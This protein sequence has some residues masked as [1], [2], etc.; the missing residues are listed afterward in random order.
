MYALLRRSRLPSPGWLDR[1]SAGTGHG[2]LGSYGRYPPNAVPVGEDGIAIRVAL[3]FYARRGGDSRMEGTTGVSGRT[4][5]E[6][7]FEEFLQEWLEEV[8]QGSPSTVEL[9]NRFAHKIITQWLDDASDPGDDLIFCDGAGDGGIDVAYL[10]R[11]EDDGGAASGS[12]WY[13]VQS[14]YGSAFKSTSTLL[15]EG[16]KIIDTRDGKRL[17]LSSL[18]EGLQDRLKNFV[19]ASGEHDRIVVAFATER[20][21][22]EAEAR[23]LEDVRAMG[24]GRFG[25]IFS[26]EAFSVESIHQR[27]LD[28]GPAQK[29]LDVRLDGHFTVSGP[30]L[31]VGS[32]PLPELY[33]FLKRYQA[34]TQDL[35][36]LYERNVRKF[37][38][39]RTKIN[40]AIGAT[41]RD[42]P[43]RFGLYNNG[44]TV[45]VSDMDLSPL[46]DGVV[47]AEPYVV[48]GCQTTRSIWEVFRSR[49]DAGATGKDADL[50]AWKD[51]AAQG[52][53][54]VKVAKVGVEGEP[55]LQQITRFTNSQNAVRD[56]DF[57][58]LTGDFRSWQS[59]LASKRSVYLEIQRGGWDSQRARQKQLPGGAQ[60]KRAANAADLMK[61]LGAGWL[62][63]AGLAYGKNAPFLPGGSAFRRITEPDPAAPDADAFGAD[64]LYAAMLL[65]EAA[66]PHGF[67]RGAKK[68]SRGQ[69]RF[70]FFMVLVDL[71]KDV[72]T[73]SGRIATRPEITRAVIQLLEHPISP[74]GQEFVEG[75]L[76][77]IDGYLASGTDD[78]VFK[79]PAYLNDFGGDLNAFLKWERLG[80]GDAC[81]NLRDA[82]ATQR[83]VVGKRI[84]DKDS[85]RDRTIQLVYG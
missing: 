27:L 43:D 75:A 54:V 61:V 29:R 73:R 56:K 36:Q 1:H 19:L 2:T 47:L 28:E 5:A 67:G 59:T 15:T 68:Q 33:T 6:Q 80:K 85:L 37:L 53:V 66:E 48:N 64:D 44:I 22:D 3:S 17:R 76:E 7:A 20:K 39:G 60:F 8:R 63:E 50:D 25:H 9:G 82:L 57:L 42:N 78:S 32:V 84:G 23:P 46:P 72:V 40:K 51:R 62:G 35:D 77:V 13:L 18:A 81:P 21:L 34:R 38:G 24:V 58:A 30:D 14:K 41:L 11:A 52:C 45:V 55:L 16:Q 10:D 49:M 71:V 83:R 4:M 65:S 69:T 26:V 70:L 12:T 31:L 79:E 74:E